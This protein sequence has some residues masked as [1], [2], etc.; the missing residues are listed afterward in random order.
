MALLNYLPELNTEV[1]RLR[2]MQAADVTALSDIRSNHKVNKYI[3]RPDRMSAEE[4]LAFIHL[5]NEGIE[6]GQ[7]YYWAICFM[8]DPQMIGAI[9]LWNFSEDSLTAELGYELHPDHH[10][11]GIMSDAVSLVI[12][13]S[14]QINCLILEAFTHY[15]NKASIQLLLKHG[16]VQ[17]PERS[18][19]SHKHNR[20]YIKDL[21]CGF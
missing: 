17:D 18:D 3:S 8:N 6:N 15:A 13:F 16:F 19:A 10:G 21:K 2:R 14:R 1:L 11:K 4:A 5:K 9:C 20:I 12:D 7:W